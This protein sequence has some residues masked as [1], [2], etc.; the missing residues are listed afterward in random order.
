MKS[1]SFTRFLILY[2]VFVRQCKF[3]LEERS[4]KEATA[5]S[6]ERKSQ[7]FLSEKQLDSVREGSFTG[8]NIAAKPLRGL[9]SHLSV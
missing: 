8:V 2:G 5:A 4:K 3:T 7:M 9:R 1:L 6:A